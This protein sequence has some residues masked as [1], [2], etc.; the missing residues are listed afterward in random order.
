MGAAINYRR[1]IGGAS[2][3]VQQF[4]HDE[5]TDFIRYL[6]GFRFIPTGS[7]DPFRNRGVTTNFDSLPQGAAFTLSFTSGGQPDEW[8]Q[9]HGVFDY[10]THAQI[11]LNGK[12]V[13]EYYRGGSYAI[14]DYRVSYQDRGN[15][16][17]HNGEYAEPFLR[18]QPAKGRNT[19][20]LTILPTTSTNNSYLYFDGI[21]LNVRGGPKH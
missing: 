5:R 21:G 20:R 2:P 15:F 12:L 19:L 6:T 1:S 7:G 3:L 10:D 9:L 13:A 17:Q 14:F 11:E 8:V 18:V 4:L 16:Y